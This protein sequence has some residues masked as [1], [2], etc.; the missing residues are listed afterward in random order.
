MGTQWDRG[1]ASCR[2]QYELILQ[3]ARHLT[4]G[5]VSTNEKTIAARPLRYGTVGHIGG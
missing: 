4:A 2:I 5:A 1:R 3:H